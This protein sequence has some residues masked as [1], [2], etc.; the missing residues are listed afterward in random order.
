[1]RILLLVLMGLLSFLQPA[2]AKEPA[3][4]REVFAELAEIHAIVHEIHS[5]TAEFVVY[6]DLVQ[7]IV[8][9]DISREDAIAKRA[10]LYDAANERIAY[11]RNRQEQRERTQTDSAYL[12]AH[13]AHLIA[14]VEQ[15]EA[16]HRYWDELVGA[17][18]D[19]EPLTRQSA[20]S[21][22]RGQLIALALAYQDIVQSEIEI[23][24]EGS[25]TFWYHTALG[26]LFQTLETFNGAL[27]NVSQSRGLARRQ[28]Q[29]HFRT[30]LSATIGNGELAAIEL[31]TALG[32]EEAGRQVADF[33]G[34]ISVLEETLTQTGTYTM[35]FLEPDAPINAVQELDYLLAIEELLLRDHRF[36]QARFE[37]LSQNP[38]E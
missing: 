8:T 27:Y 28:M 3:Q 13:E 38:A 25:P 33:E 37:A 15:F 21:Q 16:Y 4:D 2:W 5:D 1:M 32:E 18:L 22:M 35:A 14:M 20:Q 17:A 29:W 23:S 11:I 36:R 9:R 12:A 31:R 10:K 19:R 7:E 30:E 24:A 6:Y 34:H 26:E